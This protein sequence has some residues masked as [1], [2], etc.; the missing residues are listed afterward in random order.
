VTEGL[1]RGRMPEDEAG[2]VPFTMRVSRQTRATGRRPIAYPLR[3]SAL[4][5]GTVWRRRGLRQTP[6]KPA[7][8]P[9]LAAL[10]L[11]GCY[12]VTPPQ[13]GANTEFRPPRQVNPADVLL[14]AGYR[15]EVVDVLLPAGYR[16]EVVATGLTFPTGI[17]FDDQGRPHVTEAGYS[18][19]EV[20]TTPR[21]L[22]LEPGGATTE[23][24]RG[25]N[26]PWTGVAFHR[27]AFFVTGG[28]QT[29]AAGDQRADARP[30]RVA[31]LRA[32]RRHERRRRRTRQRHDGV[33][34]APPAPARRPLP[35]C[36][37][38]RREPR[39]RQPAR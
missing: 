35:R 38:R 1:R 11:A 3:P 34:A 2:S 22:R 12:G 6:L 31:L 17:A 5:Y 4:G 14:P 15:V 28:G 32:G 9:A 13:G 37:P 25:D 7:F 33:A 26:A 30:R 19:G 8:G 36:P 16:V 27:G 18:Y 10:L 39:E 24:A 20:F 21:L 23:V 29:P